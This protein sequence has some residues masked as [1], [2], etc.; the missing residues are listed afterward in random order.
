MT[1]DDEIKNKKLQY[2]INREAGKI[3]ALF[4]GK[5]DKYEYLTGEVLLPSYQSRIIEQKKFTYPPLSK[6]FVKQIKTIEDQEQN[7]LK[8]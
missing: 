1:I 7:K 6:A 8:W 3:S 2:G 5:I 4:S